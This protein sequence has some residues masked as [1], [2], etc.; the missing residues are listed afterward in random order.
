MESAAALAAAA[1]PLTNLG[2]IS[3]L[4][5]SSTGSLNF[6]LKFASLSRLNNAIK[7]SNANGLN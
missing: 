6:D 1:A 7:M 5:V 2:R 4:P 3:A